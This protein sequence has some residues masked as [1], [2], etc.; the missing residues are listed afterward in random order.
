M[1]SEQLDLLEQELLNMTEVEFENG[2]GG[3]TK[4]V[5]HHTKILSL[6]AKIAVDTRHKVGGIQKSIEAYNDITVNNGGGKP[7]TY[8]R[9]VFL[10]NVYDKL[11]FGKQLKATSQWIETLKPIAWMIIMIG[12]FA[13]SFFLYSTIKQDRID[14]SKEINGRLKELSNE[15]NNK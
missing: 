13:Y 6:L 5:E 2:C 4:V 12:W 9:Q 1:S 3:S 14:I 15:L 7:V 8:K 10:Q 11:S